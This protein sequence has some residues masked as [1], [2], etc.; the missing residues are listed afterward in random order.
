[1]I[2]HDLNIVC[3][4]VAPDE[5]QTPLFVDSNAMLSF[6]VTMQQFQAIAGWRCQ[7]AQFR[8]AV[9]L[10]KLAACNVL[11]CL[12]AAAALAPVKPFRLNTAK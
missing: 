5:A 2:V 1:M 4:P 8:R 9:R 3:V 6:S 12:K 10:S 7:I 11:D